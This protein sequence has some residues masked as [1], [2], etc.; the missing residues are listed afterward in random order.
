MNVYELIANAVAQGQSAA[1]ATVV[2][3]EGSTP[4]DVGSK[5]VV[6]DN[7]RIAGTVG[8]GK[9]EALVI[10]PLTGKHA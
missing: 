9:M 10:I 4:R 2:R 3:V 5:M 7:G 8:G 6:Y 1:L